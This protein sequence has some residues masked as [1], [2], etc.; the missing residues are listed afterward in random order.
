MHCC[1]TVLTV[2]VLPLISVQH[3]C[4][5]QISVILIFN[6]LVTLYCLMAVLFCFFAM[7][8]FYFTAVLLFS[9]TEL[10]AVLDT[11]RVW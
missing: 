4:A 10:F 8:G 9:G 5:T 1:I 3:N 6:R 11:F 7:E 2:P